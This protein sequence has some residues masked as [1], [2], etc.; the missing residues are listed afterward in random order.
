MDYLGIEAI[1]QEYAQE[2]I[3]GGDYERG[4]QIFQKDLLTPTFEGLAIHPETEPVLDDIN[5][6]LQDISID[7]VALEN[8]LAHTAD[9]YT[10]VINNMLTRLEAAEQQIQVEADRINDINAICG[11]YPQFSSV[12]SF[13]GN[14]VN[15]SYA[16]LSNS[17]VGS[18]SQNSNDVELA[19]QDVSGNGL[20]GNAYLKD[21]I[22]SDSDNLTDNSDLSKWVYTRFTAAKV[23]DGTA[24]PINGD[25]EEARAV[26][27]FT[28]NMPF[29]AVKINSDEDIVVEDVLVSYD[30]GLTYQSTLDKEIHINDPNAKYNDPAYIY[31]SGVIAFPKTQFAKIQVRSNGVTD[32]A[33]IDEEGEELEGVKC[34]KITIN[35]IRALSKS[36]SDGHIETNDFVAAPVDCIAVFANEYIPH[37]YPDQTYFKY[38]LTVNGVE[39]EVVPIN[40]NRTGTKVIRYS[41]YIVNDSYVEHLK[42]PIRSASLKVLLYTTPSNETP[43]LSNLKVCLGKVVS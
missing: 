2:K 29:Q 3:D 6:A 26:I 37:H 23:P 15:G 40:S 16:W 12:L 34:H 10:S 8:E 39:H 41:S 9:N 18:T 4:L 20:D 38:I 32:D 13:N 11:M 31:G 27:T 43:Y 21:A 35:D 24:V 22:K 28:G 7:C 17:F 33:V 25:T 42:E 14:T 5:S 36:F 19:V 30:N 1:R